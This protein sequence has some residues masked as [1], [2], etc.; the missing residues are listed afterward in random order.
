MA[1]EISVS[2]SDDN[3][4]K[5]NASEEKIK[6]SFFYLNLAK[7][8]IKHGNGVELCA[9]EKVKRNA[10]R[11][12]MWLVAFLLSVAVSTA[13]DGCKEELTSFSA[14]L[15]Y[16]SYPPN[17][18]T[19]SASENC[20]TAFSSAMEPM[21]LCYLLRDPLIL[22]F[23]LNSSRLLSLP[24]LC[25]SSNATSASFP[26]LCSSASSPALPPLNT[27]PTQPL[28]S[29][30]YI[31]RALELGWAPSQCCSPLVLGLA[32]WWFCFEECYKPKESDSSRHNTKL[33]YHELLGLD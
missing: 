3:I 11:I 4:A 27:A 10:K 7:K 9:L 1:M 25:P 19:E 15:P 18:L 2:G 22:G 6:K 12:M 16:V 30:K 14:C 23:P 26:F 33:M 29:G 31:D 13:V 8:Y 5:I 21:C 17:N 28:R 24:S 20:C 32:R